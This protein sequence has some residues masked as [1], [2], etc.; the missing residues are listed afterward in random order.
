MSKAS[1]LDNRESEWWLKL[2]ALCEKHV[3]SEASYFEFFDLVLAAIDEDGA[4]SAASRGGKK[5]GPARAMAMTSEQRSA[6]ASYAARMRWAR[7]A[8][9]ERR[10]ERE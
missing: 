10:R 9:R 4:I 5:G 8:L 1:R 6:N 7:Q 2:E 3:L